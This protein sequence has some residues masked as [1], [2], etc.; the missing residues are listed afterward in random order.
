MKCEGGG[1][2]VFLLVVE[3]GDGGGGSADLVEGR[4]SRTHLRTT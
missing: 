1:W 2:K 3:G 4:S